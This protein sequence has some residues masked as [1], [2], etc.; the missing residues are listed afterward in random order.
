MSFRHF[1]RSITKVLLFSFLFLFIFY[2]DV[3]LRNCHVE[4][5]QKLCR[6]IKIT[7][8]LEAYDGGTS[9]PVIYI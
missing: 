7:V 3:R 9:D 8:E 6:P 1:P 2:F 4:K 5:L